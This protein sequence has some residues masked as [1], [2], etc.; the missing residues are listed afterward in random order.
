MKSVGNTAVEEFYKK[1]NISYNLL[2]LLFSLLVNKVK[3]YYT[4]GGSPFYM[5]GFSTTINTKYSA[6]KP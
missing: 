2:A 6:V 5:K 1:T 4:S 3:F